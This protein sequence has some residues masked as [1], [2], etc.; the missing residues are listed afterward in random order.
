MP[1]TREKKKRKDLDAFPKATTESHL[2]E[3]V[4]DTKRR[5]VDEEV[6]MNGATINCC[7][8]LVGAI[9]GL[10]LSWTLAWK[11]KETENIEGQVP[12]ARVKKKLKN[13]RERRHH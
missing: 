7:L 4:T 5:F 8:D 2:E 11:K 12:S 13:E 9:S 1:L 3:I 6:E 10:P